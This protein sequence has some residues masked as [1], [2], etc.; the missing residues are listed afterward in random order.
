MGVA[1]LRHQLRHPAWLRGPIDVA[2]PLATALPCWL[3]NCKC[4]GMIRSLPLLC[5]AALVAVATTAAAPAH[6]R[7]PALEGFQLTGGFGVSEFSQ[8]SHAPPICC[9]ERDNWAVL[10]PRLQLTAGWLPNRHF[11]LGARLDAFRGS[12]VESSQIFP[13][14]ISRRIT[15]FSAQGVVDFRYPVAPIVPYIGLEAGPEYISGR[16]SQA[17]DPTVDV[18]LSVGLRLGVDWPI[19]ERFSF[20]LEARYARAFVTHRLGGVMTFSWTSG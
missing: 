1:V 2:F 14:G 9:G 11:K 3:S 12:S 8:E 10:G 17:D 4:L 15:S 6:A 20:G 13:D 19:S 5:T 16:F 7:E 18:E